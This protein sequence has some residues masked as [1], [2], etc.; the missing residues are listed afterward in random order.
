MIVAYVGMGLPTAALG[1]AWKSMRVDFDRPLSSLGVVVV[2]FTVGYLA[3]TASHRVVAARIGPGRPADGR[4]RCWRPAG[5][6]G[7]RRDRL[8]LVLLVGAV[9]DRACR[10]AT[11]TPPS[12]PRWRCTTA[13]A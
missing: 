13:V 12:T 3:A 8:W 7:L 9:A 2:T 5:A 6:F 11:S 1:V 10:P 4:P